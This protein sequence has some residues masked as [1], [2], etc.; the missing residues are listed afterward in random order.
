MRRQFKTLANSKE[1]RRIITYQAVAARIIDGFAQF[2]ALANLKAK[3]M[4]DPN[5]FSQLDGLLHSAHHIIL[6]Q[7]IYLRECCGGFGFMQVSGHPG[8]IERV[9][10][11][12]GN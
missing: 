8:C 7:L 6:E 3:I 2:E 12:A 9:C 10:N 5:R 1:E 11:R 4:S